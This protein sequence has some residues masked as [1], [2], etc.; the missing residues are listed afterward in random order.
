MSHIYLDEDFFL[1]SLIIRRVVGQ[2]TTIN[3]CIRQ[4]I[5]KR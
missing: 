2:W 5:F 3:H 4:K 1:M